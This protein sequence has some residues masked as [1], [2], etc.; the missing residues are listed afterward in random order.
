MY[1][2]VLPV[3]TS[4]KLMIHSKDMI[5]LNAV[6][7]WSSFRNVASILKGGRTT[8]KYKFYFKVNYVNVN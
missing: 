3:R 2:A 8:Y 1:I 4:N 6:R 7:E 5:I